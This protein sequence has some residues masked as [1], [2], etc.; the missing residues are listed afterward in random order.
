MPQSCAPA[1]RPKFDL[2]ADFLYGAPASG[3][4]VESDLRVTVDPN[5]FPAFAKYTFGSAGRAQELEPPLITLTG[6][7]HR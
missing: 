3:L 4:K 7:R 6:R 5:P 2:A 1:R